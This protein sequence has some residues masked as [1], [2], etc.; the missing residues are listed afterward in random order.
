MVNKMA[1]NTNRGINQVTTEQALEGP[2]DSFNEVFNMNIDLLKS[3]VK[4]DLIIDKYNIGKYT[5]TLIGVIYVKSIAKE[6]LVKNIEKKIKNISIDGI[7]D[8]SYLKKYLIEKNSI[9]PTIIATERPDKT[10]MALLEGKIIIMVDNSPYCLI[11]PSFFQDFFHTTDDY[12]Q[13]PINTTFIRIIRLS[14]FIISIFTPAIYISVTTRNYDL[15]PL[16]LLLTLKA[17]RN[18]VPFPAYIEAILM[19]IAFEILKE[20]DLRKNAM[21][22][23]AISILGGLILGDAAV[24]A[25]IVS[26]IMIIVIAISSISG[27]IFQ[28][29][30]LGNTIRFYKLLILILSTLLGITGVIIGAFFLLVELII[31]KS[32]GY[33]YLLLDKNE[34]YDSFIK[35]NRKIL[36]RNKT[37][38]NNEIRGKL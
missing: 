2:K 26:P 21:S 24:A 28:S 15:I 27:L 6:S 4:K 3:R 17:G 19:I 30:E 25:G 36:K 16:P 5:K 33:H 18:F 13:K 1:K 29:V 32:F 23:S 35:I 9:F 14:A 7:V 10:A 12:Y 22:A 11:M 38:T 8:S 37:L 34:I 31:T 20:G